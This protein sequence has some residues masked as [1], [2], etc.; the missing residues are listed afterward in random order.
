LSETAVSYAFEQLEP[1]DPPPRDAPARL[2]AQATAEAESIRERAR[3]EGYTEGRQE[4]H[5]EGLGEI[6]SAVQSLGEAL[7]E[8]HSLRQQTIETV[9]RDAI[10]FALALA[11]KILAG[12][13][14]RRPELVIEV[15]EGAL[16]Q[17]NDRHRV[18][19]LV[20]PADLDL[21]KDALGE[22]KARL[23]GIEQCEVQSDDRVAPGGAIARTAE[24]EVDA[25]VHTQ[26]ERARE[27]ISAQLQTRE[28]P[29]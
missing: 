18:T 25:S 22:L 23:S 29:E 15:A 2:I 19:V 5:S 7:A 14:Q 12:T 27:V 4:G 21:V 16:R 9:E 17:I 13:L 24:G 28:G 1:S 20:N 6:R 11:E 10:E 8:V 26:L 3:S